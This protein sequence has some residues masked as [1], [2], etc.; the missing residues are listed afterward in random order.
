MNKISINGVTYTSTSGDISVQGNVLSISGQEIEATGIVEIRVLE[1]SICE[2][3]ST[4]S[5]SCN[6]VTGNVNAKG[7]VNCENVDGNVKAG[8]SVNCA[9]VSGDVKAGGSINHRKK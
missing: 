8:G 5:V 9:N 6:D 4:A 2:L 7:S 3:T 1:G